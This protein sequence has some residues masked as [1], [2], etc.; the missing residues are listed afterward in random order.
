MNSGLP[1]ENNER[2][3]SY[4]KEFTFLYR[5]YLKMQAGAKLAEWQMFFFIMFGKRFDFSHIHIPQTCEGFDGLFVKPFGLS[6]RE[7]FSVMKSHIGNVDA[8]HE[9]D[10]D[11]LSSP[12]SAVDTYAGWWQLCITADEK[13]A[14]KSLCDCEKEGVPILNC[15]ERL[16]LGLWHHWKFGVHLD[17]SSNRTKLSI[18]LT[19]SRTR[20]GLALCV[21]GSNR[22]LVIGC[23]PNDR[24]RSLRP[25]EIIV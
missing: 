2:V 5:K 10:L 7:I 13:H 20:S 4:S 16:L 24:N 23:D 1:A 3:K 22:V 8:L 15:E 19:S 9:N 11:D 17:G 14:N 12:R 6:A 21:M 18:T 25:R